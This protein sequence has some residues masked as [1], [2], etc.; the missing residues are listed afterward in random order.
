[1]DCVLD[2]W[3]RLQQVL[4]FVLVL[5]I[6]RLDFEEF[7][8]LLRKVDYQIVLKLLFHEL[9]NGTFNLLVVG[10]N[11]FLVL[12]II[13][14]DFDKLSLRCVEGFLRQ[15]HQVLGVILVLAAANLYNEDAH[16]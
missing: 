4:F 6:E 14:E 7:L 9:S 16:G 10:S 3:L 8:N 13:I 11:L 15:V 2:I 12:V 5:H 1:M